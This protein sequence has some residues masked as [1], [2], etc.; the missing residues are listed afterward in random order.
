M[1]LGLYR[2][3]ATR[4]SRVVAVSRNVAGSL[5]VLRLPGGRLEVVPPAVD[6]ERF[7]PKAGRPALEALDSLS[8]PDAPRVL[9]VGNTTPTKNLETV[10]EAMALVLQRVPGAWLVVTTELETGATHAR[11]AELARLMERLGIAHRVARLGI[12]P[13][14]PLLMAACDV[15]VAPFLDTRGPSDYFMAALEAMAVGKPVVVSAVGGMPEVVD[16]E[17][18]AL[19]DPRD[20]PAMAAA[21]TGLLQDP[22]RRAAMGRAARVRAVRLFAPAVVGAAVDRVYA[23]VLS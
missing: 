11:R 14:M 21:L 23:G 8:P 6:T 16:D 1:R 20:A 19:V 7:A 15:L 18:G 13:D 9:F 22:A 12:V 10:L 17:V 4:L 5:S 3:L 2:L